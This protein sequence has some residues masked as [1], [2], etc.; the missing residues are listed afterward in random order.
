MQKEHDFEPVPGLPEA[1]PEDEY[2]LWQGRPCWRALAIEAMHTRA[3]AIYFALII[4]WRVAT[5]LNDGLPVWTIVYSVGIYCALAALGLGLFDLFAWLVEKTTFY[6]ITNRRV[7]MRIGVALSVTIN[8]PFRQIVA[9]DIKPHGHGCGTI[10]MSLKDKSPFAWSVLWPHAR[11]FHFA[12]P[13]PALRA[14]P[15][16]AHVGTLLSEALLKDLEVRSAYEDRTE[17]AAGQQGTVAVPARGR[18]RQS[19]LPGTGALA[20]GQN[21]DMRPV[22]G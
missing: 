10:A 16:A 17:V 18:L 3:V 13:Q 7:V 5:G 12:R 14:I 21:G 8:L 2:I 1:L 9:V 6:T 20:R 11:P 22:I 15:D 19:E 4:V